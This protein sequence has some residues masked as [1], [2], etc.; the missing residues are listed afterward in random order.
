MAPSR[1]RAPLQ[2]AAAQNVARKLA[3]VGLMR[4]ASG[5]QRI[6]RSSNSTSTEVNTSAPLSISPG[7][8]SV[9]DISVPTHITLSLTA[10]TPASTNNLFRQ[11]MLAY[12]ENR[13]PPILAQAP[14]LV[15]PKIQP[16]RAK[17][18][19]FYFGKSYLDCYRFY[20]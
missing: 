11:F 18:P 17:F 1:P 5:S 15:E 14:A 10:P 9:F 4:S 2:G 19:E 13:R 16:F 7:A 3:E 8:I 12:I 6:F 20:Q